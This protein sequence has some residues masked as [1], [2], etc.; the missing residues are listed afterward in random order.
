MGLPV[1][2]EGTNIVN[3]FVNNLIVC[4]TTVLILGGGIS[5]CTY[6]TNENNRMYYET[7]RAC[8]EGGGSFVPT[9]GGNSEASCIRR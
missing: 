3:S 2:I 8:I 9:K 7:M 4:I 1:F 6:V 5:G